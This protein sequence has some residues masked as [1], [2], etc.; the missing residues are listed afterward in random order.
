[1]LAIPKGKVHQSTGPRETASIL[2]AG[3]RR[4][5]KSLMDIASLSRLFHR[6][7]TQFRAEN[8]IET[9]PLSVTTYGT[10]R[11]SL[12]SYNICRLE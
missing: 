6:G 5:K 10:G 8:Y 2:G 11:I 12:E 4:W 3:L 1:M 7:V 9:E